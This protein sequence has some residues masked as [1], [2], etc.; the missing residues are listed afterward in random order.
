VTLF[1]IIALSLLGV[2]ALIGFI[3]GAVREVATVAAL[4]LA[5]FAAVFG[6]RF[7][8]RAARAALHPAWLGNAVGLIVVFLV[9]YVVLRVLGSSLTRRLHNTRGLGMADRLA[10][11][12]LGLVRGLV[13]LGV[14]NLA[15]HL[16]PPPTGLP[17]WIVNAKLYPLS[18]KC[19]QLVRAAAPR[20]SA[21]ARTLTPDF[22]RALRSGSGDESS[23]GGHSGENG[24]DDAARKGLDDV[25][26]KTR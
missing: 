8:G 22:E 17:G 14:I 3:R 9:A 11:G 7:V 21:V 6:L 18:A 1:D 4:L 20:G 2:S 5:A 13:V 10:G 19:A 16:A 26:E 15:I 12:G 23:A 25:A 24:Y